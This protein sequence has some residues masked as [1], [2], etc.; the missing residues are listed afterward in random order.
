M[1]REHLNRW[2]HPRF[3]YE[4]A[5]LFH[6]FRVAGAFLVCLLL[7]TFFPN[8]HAI[9]MLISVLAVMGS[10]QYTGSI[11]EKIHQRALG[12]LVGGLGGIAA[13]LVGHF[14]SPWGCAALE[15]VI[16]VT[17]SYLSIGRL[18][19]TAL[20]SGITM[21]MV[22]NSGDMQIAL[23]RILNVCLGVGVAEVFA[24]LIPSRAREHW[25][26][27]LGGNLRDQY[28]LYRSIAN[29][30]GIDR[31]LQDAVLQRGLKLRALSAAACQEAHLPNGRLDAVLQAQRSVLALLDVMSD[32]ST[33]IY[34][35]QSQENYT[36]SIQIQKG[37]QTLLTQ[38]DLDL[39]EQWVKGP[40][41]ETR[42]EHWL[43]H[44][45]LLQLEWLNT[46]LQAL[47]PSLIHL[48]STSQ[49]ANNQ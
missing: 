36:A 48:R 9:W 49:S 29:G 28:R 44:T 17:A 13:V 22:A 27:L 23:W 19:Y 1:L 8:P 21:V 37:F 30:Q 47:L 43:A 35:E 33:A 31:S 40:S 25:F 26:F 11:V 15:L 18:G 42:T 34:P 16:A 5:G 10:I 7:A 38:F 6:V 20:V 32:A 12:T 46:E 41:D 4:Q 14:I 3:R 2:W 39:D 24:Y 45:L